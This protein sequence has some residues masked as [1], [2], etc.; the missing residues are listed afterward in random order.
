MSEK[1]LPQPD[2]TEAYAY[3]VQGRAFH[4]RL[5]SARL[6]RAVVVSF[7]SIGLLTSGVSTASA[8]EATGVVYTVTGT[9][10]DG[11]WLHSDPGIGDENDLIKVM[12]E[13]TQFRA[14]C[15]VNDSP[16]GP[17]NNPVWLHGRDEAGSVGYFSD[18]YSSSK[19]DGSTTLEQQGLPICGNNT[20][21]NSVNENLQSYE[22]VPQFTGRY[23]RENAASWALANAQMQPPSDG[24]CT[25]FVSNVLWQGGL[26]K[27]KE[28]TSDGFLG[29]DLPVIGDISKQ[30]P[31]TYAAWN[32][33]AFRD[34]LVKTYP[35][36]QWQ[37]LD[38]TANSVPIARSGDLIFYDWGKGEGLSHVTVITGIANGNYPAVSEWSAGLDGSDAMDYQKRGWTWSE[39]SHRY[40]QKKY[41]NIKAYILHR[42][43][44]HM[45]LDQ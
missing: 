32:V 21:A 34:Y 33:V 28:W 19:W 1:T 17:R 43:T 10:G 23:D 39:V 27:T 29:R 4:S 37:Q 2:F 42:D 41:P 25:W 15:Y 20:S 6:G 9:G 44:A 3:Q 11:V 22:G 7:A 35:E 12:P 14:D 45:H 26:P 18:V 40:L 38:F 24:S 5:A 16:L 31:G 8:H 13:G 36:S 30:F